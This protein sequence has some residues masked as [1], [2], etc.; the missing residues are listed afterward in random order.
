MGMFDALEG[1]LVGEAMQNFGGSQPAVASILQMIQSQPGGISGLAQKFEEGGLGDVAKSWIGGGQN[2]PVSPQ[3]VQATLGPDAVGQVAQQM[4]VSHE[5]ASNHLAQLLPQI[6]N[7]L[8]PNG[9]APAQNELL[10][11]GEGLLS[12]FFSKR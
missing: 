4:G 6:V 9:Q 7:H 3:Q 8:T 1:Q 5:E 10:S 11:M 2:I 12:S